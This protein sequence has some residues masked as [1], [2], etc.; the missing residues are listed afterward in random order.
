M[1]VIDTLYT[2]TLQDCPDE[3]PERAR[4]QAEARYAK[5]LE[6]ALGGPEEVAAART[7][8]RGWRVLPT[9]IFR[10]Q[11]WNW[12][13]AGPRLAPLRGR[14]GFAIWAKQSACTLMWPFLTRDMGMKGLEECVAAPASPFQRVHSPTVGDEQ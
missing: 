11:T 9:K 6:Q 1:E 12:Q 7:R 8:C 13:H 14:R 2:V 10:K 3:V 4:A 5:A